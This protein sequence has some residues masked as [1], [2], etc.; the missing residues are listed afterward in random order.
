MGQ[1]LYQSLYQYHSHCISHCI[2]QWV[3]VSSLYQYQSLHQYQSLYQSLHSHTFNLSEKSRLFSGLNA[4][5]FD[6]ATGR[7]CDRTPRPPSEIFL[8]HRHR[9]HAGQIGSSLVGTAPSTGQICGS[10]TGKI[11][12]RFRK[13]CRNLSLHLHRRHN[14]RQ[15]QLSQFRSSSHEAVRCCAHATHSRTVDISAY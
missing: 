10:S 5:S 15:G 8:R 3:S 1:S 14:W 9:T 4:G 11:C 13:I 6:D 2:N 12:G 7:R